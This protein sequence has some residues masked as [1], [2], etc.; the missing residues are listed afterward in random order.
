MSFISK[1]AW[2]SVAVLLG[3]GGALAQEVSLRIGHVESPHSTTQVLLERLSEKVGEKTDGAVSFQIYPQSQLGGQR[4]MTEAVQFGALD[5]TAGPVAFMGGFNPLASIMDIP[6]LY[7]GDPQQAQAVRDSG[8]ADAFCDSFNLRGVTCIGLYPNGTKQFTS[9]RPI[10]TLEE[11]SGQKFRVMES[12]VLVKSFKPVGV[13][14]V[15][16]PFSELYTALQ[17]GIVDGEEN[18]L[19]TIFNMKFFE[20]QDYLT[21]SGHGAIE[22]VIL[23]NPAVWD[24]LSDD[25]RL[26]ITSSFDEVI[27]EMIAH[28]TAAAETSLAAIRE[29]G[30]TVTELTDDQ[31]ARFRDAMFPA[32]RDAFLRQ[33]GSEGQALFDAYQAAYD[34]V[35]N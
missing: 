16:I 17:T 7:P 31:R 2:G 30:L 14:A 4:E 32:A 11:F 27:P 35:M 28:K 21:L 20:V 18:P 13:T 12:A 34:T 24:R 29:A 19:D 8:F 23:F 26:A 6:F 1:F 5:A 15:P 3:A 9:D 10:S 22:N 25:Q 33:A